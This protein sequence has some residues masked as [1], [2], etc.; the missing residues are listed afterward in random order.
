MKQP[1]FTP[2]QLANVFIVRRQAAD[3]ANMVAKDFRESGFLDQFRPVTLTVPTH[4]MPVKFD[5][6]FGGT[7]E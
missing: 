4:F 1:A 5:V 6:R 2:G 7:N 3:L